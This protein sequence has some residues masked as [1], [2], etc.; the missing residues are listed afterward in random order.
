MYVLLGELGRKLALFDATQ[1]TDALHLR[2]KRIVEELKEN[3]AE[4]EDVDFVR[5]ALAINLK[6]TEKYHVP[7]NC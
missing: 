3:Q 6:K 1:R 2:H 4:R 5:I 7:L